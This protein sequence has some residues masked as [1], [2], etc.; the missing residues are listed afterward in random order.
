MEEQKIME[1]KGT[2]KCVWDDVVKD[3]YVYGHYTADTNELFYIGIGKHR[4][5]D[6]VGR[7]YLRAYSCA[8]SQRN[9]YWLGKYNKHGRKVE[10]L[11]D[12]LTE[13]EAKNK[14]IELI[15]QYGTYVSGTGKLCNISKGGEGR[16]QDKSMCKKTYAYNLKGELIG[17]FDSCEEAAMYY[18]L[19]KANVGVAACM[20]RKTCG[21]YQFRYEENK[22]INLITN[23]RIT[24]KIA[25]PII[26]TN[27]STGEEKSFD[28]CYKFMLYIG[29]RH[30]THILDV[31]H[32]N[33]KAVKGWEVRYANI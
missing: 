17:V 8:K 18:T 11:F 21:G 9:K 22:G 30:N 6:T 28:S 2:F 24:T 14:E 13:K 31:L 5:G 27:T 26:A 3:H 4:K 29:D 7:K 1:K 19:D 10:I 12:N 20:K 32:G 15:A 25:K 33:R 16:Y 23:N